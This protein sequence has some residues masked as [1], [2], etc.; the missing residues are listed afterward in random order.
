[1]HMC[2]E[3]IDVS[4]YQEGAPVPGRYRCVTV[5]GRYRC[6]PVSGR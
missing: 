1:V 2:L 4:L 6:A 3:G 5:P